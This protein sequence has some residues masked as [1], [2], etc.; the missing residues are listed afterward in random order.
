MIRHAA[1]V[2]LISLYSLCSFAQAQD[3]REARLADWLE[4]RFA[5]IE[6][7]P[8]GGL[9]ARWTL[10]KSSTR[11]RAEVDRRWRKVEPYPDHPER[12]GLKRHRELLRSPERHEGTIWY[13]GGDAWL[14]HQVAPATGHHVRSGGS[15]DTRWMLFTSQAKGAPSGGIGQLTVIREGIPHPLMYNVGRMLDVVRQYLARILAGESNPLP[16]ARVVDIR[17]LSA[18]RWRGV[19]ES[20]SGT[21]RIEV[22]GLRDPVSGEPLPERVTRTTRLESGEVV[23]TTTTV[24]SAFTEAQALGRSVATRIVMDRSGDVREVYTL[25]SIDAV[26]PAEIRPL[27]AVPDTGEGVRVM[28]YRSASSEAWERY[29]RSSA[30]TWRRRGGTDEYDLPEGPTRIASTDTG[31]AP[32]PGG[33]T[34]AGWIAAVIGVAVLLIGGLVVIASRWRKG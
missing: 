16:D 14:L 11:S 20:E 27:A 9:V 3:E 21:E 24:L 10:E 28:D 13:A 5:R 34:H 7:P 23:S 1:V 12:A 4:H 30:M 22:R 15:D 29:D 19:L 32:A 17:L 33:G 6:L 26:S 31:S 18:T 8:A 2:Q 25:N